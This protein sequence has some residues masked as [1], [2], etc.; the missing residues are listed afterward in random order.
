M[1]W[2]I[3]A[4][5]KFPFI[6][7]AL[8]ISE[9]PYVNKVKTYPVGAHET[10]RSNFQDIKEYYGLV[11]L[12][13]LPPKNLWLPI[14]PYRTDKLTFPLCAACSTEKRMHAACDHNDN[15]RALVG[16][17]CTPE[18]CTAVEYGYVILEVYEVWHYP[19]RR[20][21]LFE[22]YINLF[23]ALK[24]QASGWP[25][26]VKTEAEKEQYVE[27]FFIQESV[28]LDP[29][30]IVKNPGLRALAKLCLNS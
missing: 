15:E 16:T 27:E 11:Y 26:N 25:S 18:I 19:S 17:W 3:V 7:P 10:I 2:Q 21:R 13:I 23:L 4:G 12:K 9:Y 1:T 8:Q 6:F 5:N 22:S 28:R 29:Q 24:V 30:K 14:L 20:D